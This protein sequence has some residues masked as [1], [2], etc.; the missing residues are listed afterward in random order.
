M[1]DGDRVVAVATVDEVVAE[2]IAVIVD[3][4]VAAAA[5]DG[6]RAIARGDG[7]IAATGIDHV[8]AIEGADGVVTTQRRHDI[9]PGS[10]VEDVGTI[11]TGPAYAGRIAA[12]RRE[13]EIVGRER[14][15]LGIPEN[16]DVG[17]HIGIRR[18]ARCVLQMRIR[19]DLNQSH[20]TPAEGI[21][22]PVP[23]EVK[24]AV[25]RRKVDDIARIARH[26]I[27]HDHGSVT[28]IDGPGQ[29]QGVD[30][31]TK[32]DCGGGP[33]NPDFHE[34]VVGPAI[35]R[36]PT[37]IAIDD[38]MV[39]TSTADEVCRRRTADLGGQDI[40]AIAA[41]ETGGRVR[42]IT[43]TVVDGQ[44]VIAAPAVCDVIA[45]ADRDRIVATF[46][47]DDVIA[48]FAEEDIVARAAKDDIVAEATGQDVIATHSAQVIVIIRALSRIVAF[49]ADPGFSRD[50]R[51]I[52][53]VSQ[54]LV[55]KGADLRIR[56]GDEGHILPEFVDL[57]QRVRP[58][59][60]QPQR[61]GHEWVGGVIAGEGAEKVR[62]D[63]IVAIGPGLEIGDRNQVLET[64]A[65]GAPQ[66]D[67]ILSGAERKRV[68][69]PVKLQIETVVAIAAVA[70]DVAGL[71]IA[72]EGVVP[73]A[74]TQR[75]RGAVADVCFE[76]I[77]V[78]PA[79][80]QDRVDRV[81]VVTKG[82]QDITATATEHLVIAVIRIECVVAAFAI[83]NVIAL[84]TLE[85]V[86]AR[87]GENNVIARRIL[88][89]VV[90]CG[91]VDLCHATPTR[92]S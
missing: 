24:L 86:I 25:E 53:G 45:E 20:V 58:A 64:I 46:A 85:R 55:G 12:V 43:E 37:G 7:V 32:R 26:E 65:A 42:A 44:R 1:D 22:D 4:V 70:D 66:L 23:T 88:E 57:E 79:V 60:D 29:S 90:A 49:G 41:F 35:D 48:L 73:A 67:R 19:S 80:E 38:E 36:Y 21:A 74:A 54:V 8:V 75:D 52:G 34:V 47:V 39:R 27:G 81:V 71:T 51:T 28:A 76:E 59:L 78:G 77:I 68:G 33:G 11:G 18:P 63:D 84:R 50:R 17:I 82:V 3:G 91:S 10:P 9:A 72:K 15:D 92:F 31:R 30:T 87:P 61:A 56:E 2:A 13:T 6:V 14:A 89:N 5:I 62:Q 16:R 40:I 83:G 69:D